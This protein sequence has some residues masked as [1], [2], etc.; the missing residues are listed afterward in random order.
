MDLQGSETAGCTAVAMRSFGTI[1]IYKGVKPYC[2]RLTFL[3]SFGIIR[4]YKGVKLLCDGC[5]QDES[6]GTI[7]I[8]R[9]VKEVIEVK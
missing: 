9:V 2:H 5:I 1:W 7:R 3:S 6:F 8:C 4:I